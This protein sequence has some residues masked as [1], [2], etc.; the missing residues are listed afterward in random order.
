MRMCTDRRFEHALSRCL[1]SVSRSLYSVS[2]S[3]Y[4]RKAG[5][6]RSSRSLYSVSRSL[7]S[8]RMS[9]DRR[10]EHALCNCQAA[11]VGYW[12]EKQLHKS[13]K[14]YYTQVKKKYYT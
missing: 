11:G 3:L 12:G 5:P 4:A 13:K 2:R 8:V 7:Y 10:F 1:Y 6:S 14:K 9:T